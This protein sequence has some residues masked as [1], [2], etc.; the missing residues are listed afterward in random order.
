M[1]IPLPKILA[2]DVA[3]KTGW[4]VGYNSPEDITYGTKHFTDVHHFGALGAALSGFIADMVH[5]HRPDIIAMEKPWLMR[6]NVARRL[7]GM[8][9]MV[10]VVAHNLGI[11]FREFAPMSIKKHWVGSGRADKKQMLAAA[12]LRGYLPEDDNQ[13]DAIAL[14]DLT[15]QEYLEVEKEKQKLE[16]LKKS[17]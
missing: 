9:F 4:A 3:T 15:V 16:K 7:N 10:E 2:L 17:S 11:P 6:N 8:C 1:D 12:K 5:D 13:A 14:L